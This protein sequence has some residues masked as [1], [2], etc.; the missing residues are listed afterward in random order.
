MIFI[1]KIKGD[2]FSKDFVSKRKVN[3][4]RKRSYHRRAAKQ[5]SPSPKSADKSNG[6]KLI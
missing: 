3:V 5:P 2:L 4:S 6:T 1:L